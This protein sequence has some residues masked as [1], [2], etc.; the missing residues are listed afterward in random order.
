MRKIL[1]FLAG[2]CAIVLVLKLIPVTLQKESIIR[3]KFEYVDQL[4]GDPQSWKKWYTPVKG[5][6]SKDPSACS[7]ENGNG[8]KAFSV[9]IPGG[10]IKVELLQGLNY[11]IDLS[12]PE[13][14]SDFILGILPG[15]MMKDA[16]VVYSYKTNLLARLFPFVATN[17]I[18]DAL[19]NDLKLFLEDSRLFYGFN[20]R[21]APPVGNGLIVK[22]VVVP[23]SMRFQY[24]KNTFQQLEHYINSDTSNQALANSISYI[25]ARKDS[26]ELIVGIVMHKSIAGN[27]SIRFMQIPVGQQLL[28]ADFEGFYGEKVNVYTAMARYMADHN[29]AGRAGMYES[30]AP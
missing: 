30:F 7:F 17:N 21:V 8:D 1:F 18:T 24:V 22:Q 14:S 6:C 29:I 11:M 15:E 25:P 16:K 3:N 23:K 9:M 10:H 2:I 12:L 26:V 19:I 4:I 28:V 5:L 27:D 20:I 13:G